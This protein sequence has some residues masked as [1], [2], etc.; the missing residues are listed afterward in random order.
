VY[1]PVRTL[2]CLSSGDSSGIDFLLTL[3][4]EREDLSRKISL[5]GSNGIQFGMS[6]GDLVLGPLVGAQATDGD[7]VQRPIGS[8]IAAGIETMPDGFS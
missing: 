6:L 7:K 2:F 1:W 5:Q 8:A 4:D 3:H